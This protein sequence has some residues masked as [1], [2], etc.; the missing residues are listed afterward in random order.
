MNIKARIKITKDYYKKN[1]IMKTLKKVKYKT[2]NFAKNR[3][4]YKLN[5]ENYRLWIEKNEP[6]NAE[7]EQQRKHVFEY[8][9]KI[10]VVVPMY[11]TKEVF[12]KDIVDS[13][14]KQT[15]KNWELCLAD[16]SPSKL[17]YVDKYINQS[18]KIQYKFLNDNKGISGNTNCAIEM[19]TGEYIALLDHDDLLPEFS[20]YEIVSAIN[21][22]R[23]AEFLYTDEDKIYDGKRIEPHFKPDY[24]PDTLMS[25]NYICHFAI[26][27]KELFKKTGL[28]NSEFDGSQD[29]DIILRACENAN[30]IVHIPKILYNWRMNEDSVALNSSAKPYAY[31]AAKR[32]IKAHLERIGEEAE[33]CDSEIVGIYKVNYK[34]KGN[35]K[36]SI[37]ISNLDSNCDLKGCIKSICKNTSYKNIEI[38]VVNNKKDQENNN[39]VTQYKEVK[40]KYVYRDDD[41]TNITALQNLGVKNTD[42]EY[43]IFVDSHLKILSTNWV[44]TL[45]GNCQRKDVGVVGAK[46]LLNNSKIEH[47]GIIFDKD[48]GISYVSRGINACESGYMA[49]NNIIQNYNAVSGKLLIVSKKNFEEVEALDER[50]SAE[51]ADIDL[52]LKL[53]S[54]GKVNILN[55]LVVANEHKPGNDEKN[56]DYDREKED[57]LIIK[58]KWSSMYKDYDEYYNP[59][60]RVDVPDMSIKVN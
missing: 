12:L 18:D 54:I 39:A 36:V 19:A 52:C 38:I 29:Y 45:L 37:I 13:M 33:V 56:R 10:S 51:Y 35:P 15:Y 6:N 31:E 20:L 42:A 41:S 25:Y 32:A 4:R 21:N 55:P 27:K 8:E 3:K 49:R 2:F 9:P 26:Y 47:V 50:L 17:E 57:K 59:N 43:I 1:G 46:I 58:T 14:L 40:I 48:N 44:E 24:A 7:L 53:K 23:D 5:A 11:N 34:I 16:G 30:K 60:F 22:N 28:L